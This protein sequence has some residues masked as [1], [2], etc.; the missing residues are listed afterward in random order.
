M[1]LLN[2]NLKF[3][4]FLDNKLTSLWSSLNDPKRQIF[5]SDKFQREINPSGTKIFFQLYEQLH[6]TLHIQDMV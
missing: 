3:C 6:A 1:F 2:N 4:F 5:T